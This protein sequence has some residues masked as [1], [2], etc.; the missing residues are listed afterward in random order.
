M[1]DG[2]TIR[3]LFV[4]DV[5]GPI[6]R[7]A[8][9]RFLPALREQLRVDAVIINGENSA[10]SGM[11]ATPESAAGLLQVADFVTLGDHAFDQESIRPY[12]DSEPRIIRPANM[13]TALPGRG[14]ATFEA[15]ET[16]PRIGVVNV[17]GKLFMKETPESP[18]SAADRAVK[19]LADEGVRVIVVDF[20][21]EATSEKQAMGW[22]LAGR[23]TAVLGTH[24]HVP[25]ADARILPGGTAYISD[26][27]MTGAQDGII[28]F[29]REGFS[30]LILGDRSAGPPRP[31]D[32]PPQIN[33]V[34]I[35][36]DPETGH[37]TAF[38]PVL[39]TSE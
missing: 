15:A 38:E 33:A 8:A 26:V 2:T 36:L 17:M 20:Q 22:Y 7:E 1:S 14:W 4:G 23:A 31:A 18:Y 32:G 37:A 11:G 24:T 19:A 28:G 34:V 27:G 21:A 25:T 16:G 10:D 39:R 5:V 3:L 13:D 30:R 12:L 35:E 29:G 6:G 9:R